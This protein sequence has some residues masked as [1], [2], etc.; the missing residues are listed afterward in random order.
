MTVLQI[1]FKNKTTE[2]ENLT[3]ELACIV[4]EQNELSK[5][6]AFENSVLD[7]VQDLA[8]TR[9]YVVWISKIVAIK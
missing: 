8:A 7:L 3:E 9:R 1:M 5:E 4:D 2:L 6:N